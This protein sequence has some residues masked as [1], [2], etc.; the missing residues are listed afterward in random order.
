MNRGPQ[1]PKQTSKRDPAR[2]TQPSRS[3][4]NPHLSRVFESQSSSRVRST[5]T[6]TYLVTA[7]TNDDGPNLNLL[8]AV[9]LHAEVL[10]VGVAAVLRRTGP[11]FV[12]ALDD[13]RARLD[14]TAGAVRRQAERVGD[15]RAQSGDLHGVL[16]VCG[17]EGDAR[18]CQ[19][20]ARC[21]AA[22]PLWK[23]KKYPLCENTSPEPSFCVLDVE[24]FRAL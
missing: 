17:R 8:L 23:G 13:G 19:S 14:V 16:S 22:A 3:L 2:L 6:E 12:R 15:A 1:R 20:A 24:G 9:L 4:L 11:L 5:T 10:R 18:A 7:L 21:V